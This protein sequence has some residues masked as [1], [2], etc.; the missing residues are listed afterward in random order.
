MAGFCQR[1]YAWQITKKKKY[2]ILLICRGNSAIIH[3]GGT[4]SHHIVGIYHCQFWILW[5]YRI[6]H[7]H[8]IAAFD[9]I[10]RFTFPFAT[11]YYS[12][13]TANL[14]LKMGTWKWIIAK[15]GMLRTSIDLLLWV[16][17]VAYPLYLCEER[18]MLIH[19]SW[20]VTRAIFLE[21]MYP[22]AF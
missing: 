10:T 1:T 7:Q 2:E 6:N 18:I 4:S 19:I 11:F 17:G 20:T 3:F 16:S 8:A 5:I 21:Y 12:W 14:G 13:R 22:A 9:I 15:I